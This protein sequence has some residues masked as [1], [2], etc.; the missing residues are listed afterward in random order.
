MTTIAI[1]M[2]RDEEDVIA[3]TVGHMRTQVDHVI[4]ADNLSCDGTRK[5]LEGLDVEVVDDHDPAYMQS[6]KMTRL[7]WMAAR[8][9]ADWI[10][11]FDADEW[12]YSPFGRIADVLAEIAPQWLCAAATLYD[13]V[14]TAHDPAGTD[15]T[16][17]IVWRRDEPGRLP[18]VACRWRDDL[19]IEQGNHWA[20]YNGGAT[21]RDGLLVVRH[22][23]YRSVDQMVR[24][25]RNGSAAYAATDLPEDVGAHW[26]NY[27]RILELGGED[28]IGEVFRKW[29]WRKDPT[30]AV[31]IEGERQGALVYDPVHEL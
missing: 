30:K 24:K 8:R 28:A 31:V 10:V 19:I 11:P 6:V 17:T 13:H 3:A 27:G 7:A 14:A 15:P 21:V 26:R 22:F 23:P 12:W 1:S 20:R 18:K 2:V 16:Q 25:A 29:F 9:G 5:I 4:V